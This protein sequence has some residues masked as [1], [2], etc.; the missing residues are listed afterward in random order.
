MTNQITNQQNWRIWKGIILFF[1]ACAIIIA[2]SISMAYIGLAGLFVIQGGLL[3]A[4]V[5]PCLIN[6]TPLKEVFPIKKFTVRDFFGAVL[7]WMG[8]LSFGFMSIILAGIL[9]PST[10][11]G[12]TEGLGGI[13]S[14]GSVLAVLIGTVLL[15]P[16]CEEAI[17]R[18]AIL[19]NFRNIKKDWVIIV[20]V[21]LCFALLHMD[22]VRLVNT[23]IMGSI[24]AYLVVKRNNIILAMMVHLLNNG[25]TI[26]ISLLATLLADKTAEAA[27]TAVESAASAYNFGTL[28]MIMCVFCLAPIFFVL[29][30]NLIKRQIEISEGKKL[31]GV[32]LG[33]K[34]GIAGAMSAALLI[35]GGILM[36]TSA[37]MIA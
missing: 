19:S 15:P 21:G 22:P 35:G 5:I 13:V 8:G 3:V 1:I 25:V 34:L 16:I 36:T 18:G 20:L 31:G 24:C 23:F 14:S 33:V 10:T 9:F 17:T 12:V 28:G 30:Q 7:M 27:D 32:K 2:G 4:A 37:G 29:G 26:G 11:Q 6:K